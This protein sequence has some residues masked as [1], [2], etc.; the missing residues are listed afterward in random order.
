MSIVQ[1]PLS[2]SLARRERD[3]GVVVI[4][5]GVLAFVDGIA[6]FP[7]GVIVINADGGPALDLGVPAPNLGVGALDL[8]D[9]TLNRG[10]PARDL[11]V[12]ALDRGVPAVDRGVPG[13]DCGVVEPGLSCA[14]FL[15][16]FRA[17]ACACLACF[18]SGCQNSRGWAYSI[19]D[20]KCVHILSQSV[21]N[22]A[23]KYFGFVFCRIS[24][25]AATD[26][27]IR[28][29]TANDDVSVGT[30]FLLPRPPFFSLSPPSI[31]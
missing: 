2:F 7:V 6:A 26:G 4:A 12:G 27:R 11:G 17:D 25:I 9:S 8:G 29:T 21:S 30:V 1:S 28:S 24:W 20:S 5:E 14:D 15:V 10:V 3:D 23:L 18:S 22:A 13:L 16:I 19:S 31:S